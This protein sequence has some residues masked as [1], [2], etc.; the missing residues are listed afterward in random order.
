VTQREELFLARL[1][2]ATMAARKPVTEALRALPLS[3]QGSA[4]E[5][6]LGAF[7]VGAEAGEIPAASMPARYSAAV[8]AGMA[9]N[10]VEITDFGISVRHLDRLLGGRLLATS[11]RLDWATLLRR[12]YAVDVLACVRCGSA[13]APALRDH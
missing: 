6:I 12:T 9:R 13:I 2:E 1:R 10:D 5:R 3:G 4:T 11:P 7:I 8:V